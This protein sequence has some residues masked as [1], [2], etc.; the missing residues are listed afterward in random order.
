[1]TT[2]QERIVEALRASLKDNER[3]RK[4]NERLAAVA[5][6]PIAITGM[7]CR[8]PGGVRTPEDFWRLLTAG[9][10]GIG[11]FPADRG[12]D[13]GEESATAQGGFLYDAA[14][15][16][17]GFF[18]IGPRE[19][20]AMDPQQRLLLEASW[21]AVERAGIDPLTLR[22]SRTGVFAGVMYHD[23]AAR[24]G[25]VPDEVAAYLG[26]GSA[27]SVA[28]GRVSYAM[29]LEGPAVTVD[30]ACSSSLVT[31]HLAVQE[32]RRRG[33]DLALA[34]GVAVMSTPGLFVE[35]T[36]QKGLA[37][38]GRC[39]AFADAAD[40]TGF[41]EGVGMLVLER[42]SDARR[43]GHPVLAVLR[44]SAVNQDGASNGLTAPNGPAQERVIRQ[45]LA[46]AG[47]TAADVDAVE[48]H[49][50]GTRLGDPIE[51]QALLA[52]YGQ[53][54]ELPLLLGSVKSNIGHTQS[55]AGVAGVIK[56]V[57]ALRHGVLPRTLHVDRP[58]SHVDWSAG[59]VELLTEEREWPVTGRPRRAGVSSFGISGTNAH[60]IVEQAPEEQPAEGQSTEAPAAP[61]ATPAPWLLAG[62]TEAAVR[63]Q[64]GQLAAHLAAH[65]G[66]GAADVAHSLA[67][68]R[69]A[70]PHRAVVV[71]ADRGAL[72]AFAAGEEPARVVSGTAD[73]TGKTVFVFPGQGS[74]WAG[75][76]VELLDSE[77]VFAQRITECADALAEFTDWNLTDVLRGTD[78]APGYDR[79]DVVQPALWAVMVSLATLWQAH[80]VHPDAVIGHSQGEIAA[81]TVAGALTLHDA[82][83]VVALRSQAITAI[84]GHGGMVSIAQPAD[85]IDLTP[86]HH[87][88]SVAAVNGPASTVVA[89]DADALDE[90]LERCTADGIRAR[91]VPVDYASHSAHVEKLQDELLRLLAPVTPRTAATP[92][93]ST[94]DSQWLDTTTMDA[95]YWYRNL[96]HPV[97]LDTAVRALLAEGFT[98]YVETSPHPVL[99]PGLQETLDE[100]TTPTVT[101]GTLRR[102][103]GGPTAFLTSAAQLHVRGVPVDFSPAFAGG[104]RIDL[105][106]Y[107][108]QRTR[109][110][111]EGPREDATAGALFRTLWRPVGGAR[112][113]RPDGPIGVLGTAPGAT[114]GL[115][116]Y[117]DLAA[118]AA[119]DTVPATVLHHLPAAA[120]PDAG[121]P[122][123][124][125]AAVNG[126]LDLLRG[127]LAEPRLAGSRLVLATRRAAGPGLDDLALA[128]VWGLVRCAQA[129]Y[130]GQFA[131][132]DLDGSAASAAAVPA[133]LATDEPQLVLREGVP[134]AARLLPVPREAARPLDPA[135]TVLVTGGTGTLGA[136]LA[137]HLVTEHG[138]RH[139]LLTSRS[140][141][142]APG[143]DH[144]TAQLTALGATVTVT[145]CDTADRHQLE[146]LLAA[147]P[148]DHPLT[149]VVHTA[150]VLDDGIVDALTPERVDT[151][152]RPKVDAAVHLHELTAGLDLAA[153]VLFSSA[154]AT[155]GSAGQTSYGA[156]NAFLDALA[157]R[158]CAQGLPAQSLAW[159][160]WA[161]TSGMTGALG[162]AGLE[163]MVRGGVPPLSSAEGL[164]LFDAALAAGDATLV[165]ARLDLPAIGRRAAPGP[166]P[167][168][169]RDLA[170]PAPGRH[171]DHRAGT[172]LPEDSSG[173]S[174]AERLAER[175]AGAGEAERERVLLDLVRGAVAGVLGHAGPEEVEPG[176][177]F[178]ELGF[179]SLT[180]LALRNRLNAATGLR[181][182]TSLIYDQ[183][184]PALLAAHLREHLTQRPDGTAAGPDDTA[185]GP[186]GTAGG[187]GAAGPLATLYWQACERGSSMAA[188]DLLKAAAACRPAFRAGD[189]A[190]AG[191]PVRLAEGP[192]GPVLVCLPSF[193]P[194]SGPHEYARFA[195]ACRGHRAVLVLPQPGFL[196]GE[197]PPADLD[198]LADLHARSVL[199][200]TDG[201]PFVLL[202]R[203]AGGWTAHA[204]AARLERLGAAPAGLALVDSYAPDYDQLPLLEPSMSAAMKDR[205]SAFALAD[206]TRLAAMGAYHRIFAGWRPERIAAPTLLV[207]AADP[208]TEEIRESAG[209]QAVWSLPHTAVDTPGDH[210]SVLEDHSATTARTVL[211]WLADAVEPALA[212]GR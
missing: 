9:G 55:A 79:V 70:F 97:Q 38:D 92:F 77:P 72:E 87:R 188:L 96:R 11:P 36:R 95:A 164:A 112:T 111:L 173:P 210:F 7:A 138:V 186:G 180:A 145:A 68:G 43:N 122:T 181:L 19:A 168:L 83:R 114:D 89:G 175:L 187:A 100:T 135:G 105:P 85:H 136:L 61:R 102:D 144:L 194:V 151:V 160:L 75:M 67:T 64:A 170:A 117:P 101:T 82:A 137:R 109:Y 161:E 123:A 62:R 6:E 8:L 129:E 212:A 191:E 204:V 35:F 45:A 150:G 42:L 124:V 146:T 37:A 18:G 44:G 20:L 158:R 174:A 74:Q 28:T 208:W 153:F 60:V 116:H 2:P 73:V 203:S 110:W 54:R 84:A 40:G 108:F 5:D 149:A 157:E 155:L 172:D 24:L 211:A 193:G 57:L 154:A 52:T 121:L 21:E 200:H 32:L 106:T 81:A 23:Y 27:G 3:L 49:G 99:V 115:V 163:R 171:R 206:D 33:C 66:L 156:A 179:D 94:V 131:L 201:R 58:S 169:L 197:L 148:A 26:N 147:I 51:A 13:L 182:A 93:W 132:L 125:R 143:A 183:P 162:E 46:A 140:G 90:L 177:R 47:L 196:S 86:W 4:Q 103:Q 76:A 159:G 205:E 118:L 165:T 17:P 25:E 34:G 127:W 50:T 22:G 166:L 69:S 15:F 113:G 207:R 141:P 65:P 128:P 78:G 10:D 178:L 39:K 120:G 16:D 142:H 12:W 63:A 209:W 104:R 80:G 56:T 88:I 192:D 190:P 185:A 71:D 14:E 119:A 189:A 184:S 107:P 59:A 176:R 198:A 31:I 195:A 41:S 199:R 134:Y 98:T 167:A 1:M 53:E 202:G 130:P 126:T 29:G 30:T 152:L 133:A 48:A 91:R 139:L